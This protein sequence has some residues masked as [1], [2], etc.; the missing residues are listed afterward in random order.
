MHLFSLVEHTRPPVLCHLDNSYFKTILIKFA[1]FLRRPSR[2][3]LSAL[4][5]ETFTH[6][7]KINKIIIFL[8]T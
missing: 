8:I 5:L 6:W 3:P 2:P 7:I 1:Y 4:D